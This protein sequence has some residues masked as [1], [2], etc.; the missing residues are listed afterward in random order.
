MGTLTGKVGVTQTIIKGSAKTVA[1]Q[2]KVGAVAAM[3]VGMGMA[4]IL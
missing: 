1:P 3:G 4:G 2:W